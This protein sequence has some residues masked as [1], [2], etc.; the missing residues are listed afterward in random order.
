[1]KKAFFLWGK[2]D[3]MS[4]KVKSCVRIKRVVCET[5]LHGGCLRRVRAAMALKSTH[6]GGFV[7]AVNA[8]LSEFGHSS[9]RVEILHQGFACRAPR[10]KFQSKRLVPSKNNIHI[11]SL[12]NK[13]GLAYA[14]FAPSLRGTT[15][16]SPMRHP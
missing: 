8:T 15:R 1:V 14:R 7:G 2:V 6:Y 11:C 10:E 3:G 4:I 5:V 13:R 9:R 12:V 16:A